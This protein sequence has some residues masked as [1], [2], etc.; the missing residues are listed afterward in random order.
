MSGAMHTPGPWA[1]FEVGDRIK[2]MCPAAV[3]T[4]TS[5]L[6]V[7]GEDETTFA[8]VL[9]IAD[10]R[11]IAAA[12]DLLE[13]LEDVLSEWVR[14]LTDAGEEDIEERAYVKFARAAISKATGEQA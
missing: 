12:P 2:R 7:V 13:A 3:E 6:T 9:E 5:I 10:A 14:D 8:A 4:K 1:L 11:L